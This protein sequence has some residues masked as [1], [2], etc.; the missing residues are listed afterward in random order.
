MTSIAITPAKRPVV[1]SVT[2]GATIS[3]YQTARERM[4]A[5]RVKRTRNASLPELLRPRELNGDTS[6]QVLAD[7]RHA[8]AELRAAVVDIVV[9]SAR[10]GATKAD[11]IAR[12]AADLDVLSDGGVI[13]A[14]ATLA[15]DV[16]GWIVELY[17]TDLAADQRVARPRAP[18]RD[19]LP[20]AIRGEL[21]G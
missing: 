10:S 9:A 6:L 11:V 1:G 21:A 5:L 18:R 15:N 19:V 14:D 3:A 4:E 8:R 12:I 7:F 17:P 16:I 2:L 20:F 13:E